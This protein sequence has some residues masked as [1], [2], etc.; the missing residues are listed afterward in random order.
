[1]G[2][3]SSSNEKSGLLD[4]KYISDEK[5]QLE[6]E[7]EHL[8]VREDRIV[9]NETRQEE[10]E[11]ELKEFE[12]NVRAGEAK[13]KAEWQK[14]DKLKKELDKREAELSQ[15]E[16]ALL[17]LEKRVTSDPLEIKP[18][19]PVEK[20]TQ[21]KEEQLREQFEKKFAALNAEKEQ[22]NAAFKKEQQLKQAE[23]AK[24]KQI[25]EKKERRESKGLTALFGFGEKEK[26]AAPTLEI[27]RP[28]GFKHAVHVGYDP[29]HGFDTRNLPEEWTRLFAKAGVSDEQLQDKET[30]AFIVSY[31]AAKLVSP[32]QDLDFENSTAPPPQKNLD[33]VEPKND[34]GKAAT[35]QKAPPKP[36][37]GAVEDITQPDTE[38]VAPPQIK[39]TGGAPPPPTG[40]G[41]PKL[42]AVS[43][44]PKPSKSA[45]PPAAV[46]TTTTASSG[47]GDMLAQIRA[48]AKLKKV[49]EAPSLKLTVTDEDSI[50][51]ALARALKARQ[52]F[53]LMSS[54]EE[55]EDDPDGD[56]DWT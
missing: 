8:K 50:A 10:R 23:A 2:C 21:A 18:A 1:M 46:K 26:E 40:E 51:G 42:D 28:T 17:D 34:A 22:T 39:Q 4:D 31:V 56:Q 11:A 36:T 16:K 49:K 15:K 12:K 3:G 33:P 48:G 25:Q 41:P 44:P 20:L 55:D 6:T 30:A 9:E 7:A 38:K 24:Q 19:V 35:T 13:L 14:Y 37:S 5:K 54:E 47:G 45:P 53:V 43:A 27:S 32:N 29:E 52:K